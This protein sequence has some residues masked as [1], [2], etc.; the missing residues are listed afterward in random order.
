MR[1]N[2]AT[3]SPARW[4]LPR[5]APPAREPAAHR[6][7]AAQDM[8]TPLLGDRHRALRMLLAVCSGI[9][10]SGAS[11]SSKP[12]FPRRSPTL[13]QPRKAPRRL[14]LA[15]GVA[16]P[17]PSCSRVRP[18]PYPDSAAQYCRRGN[19]FPPGLAAASATICNLVAWKRFPRQ[20]PVYLFLT[21]RACR[22]PLGT[23]LDGVTRTGS[24]SPPGPR[25]GKRRPGLGLTPPRRVPTRPLP[26]ACCS[27][28]GRRLG[29]LH[30]ALKSNSVSNDKNKS[31]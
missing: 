21:T 7:P 14:P 23:R 15:P 9:W 30:N 13:A 4:E 16:T 22:A 31:K 18:Q 3:G 11:D 29:H 12:G 24:S 6:P 25:T 27:T 19:P 2:T 28:T 10:P 26:G 5:P 17:P 1:F 20:R 8:A